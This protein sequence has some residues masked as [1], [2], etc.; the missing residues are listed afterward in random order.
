MPIQVLHCEDADAIRAFE[1]EDAAYAA[2][3]DPV[4][5]LLFPGPP[6]ANAIALR[7]EQLLKQKHADPT[8]VW[9]KAVDD[10]SG[11][12]IGFAQWHVYDRPGRDIETKPPPKQWGEG[13]NPAVC[14]EFF[15]GIESGR[16][17]LIG[18]KPH[19]RKFR[20]SEL[21]ALLP[22]VPPVAASSFRGGE[23]GK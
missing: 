6:T 19:V 17:R 4:S 9:L 22:Y 12:M 18:G 10:A 23:L 20:A 13:S 3:A 16:T 15:G 2:A 5:P 1:I 7:A 21:G 14:K 8:T 11:E